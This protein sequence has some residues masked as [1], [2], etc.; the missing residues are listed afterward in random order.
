MWYNTFFQGLPQRAWR[1]AQTDEQTQA[2]LELLVEMLDFGPDDALLDVFCGYG[3]HALPLARM[4]CAVTGVDISAEYI[5]DLRA[6]ATAEN[7]S[8]AAVEGDFMAL[9]DADFA[10][11]GLFDAGYCLGNSFS[12]FP[13]DQMAVFLRRIAGLLRPGG[14]FLA[15]SGMI[16][17]VIL[18]DY[19]ERSWLPVGDDLLM[20]AEHTYHP[21][22]SRIEQHLRYIQIKTGTETTVETRLAQ[23]YVYTLAELH[24]LFAGAGLVVEQCFGTVLGDEFALGDEGVW[25]LAQKK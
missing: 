12:F 11:L 2:E 9:P 3:R 25:L 8:V 22:E 23:H 14:R 18:P 10:R 21:A 15:H 7:L 24:R 1:E 5:A 13:A 6:D 16:A 4:G 17:E 19:Q 20:L